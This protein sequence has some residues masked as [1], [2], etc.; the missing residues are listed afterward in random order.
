VIDLATSRRFSYAP[1]NE[2]AERLATALSHPF[3]VTAG[4]LCDLH[5]VA[6]VDGGRRARRW[7]RRPQRPSIRRNGW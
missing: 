5:P 4:E 6:Q 7:H 2:R 3:G 1:L